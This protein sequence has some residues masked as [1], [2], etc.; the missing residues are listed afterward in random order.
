MKSGGNNNIWAIASSMAHVLL[1]SLVILIQFSGGIGN[2]FSLYNI[3]FIAFAISCFVMLISRPYKQYLATLGMLT[4]ALVLSSLISGLHLVNFSAK[5]LIDILTMAL[6]LALPIIL[7]KGFN[8]NRLNRLCK[9]FILLFALITIASI[10][11]YFFGSNPI[12]SDTRFVIDGRVSAGSATGLP[13]GGY[14][15]V[16]CFPFLYRYFIGRNLLFFAVIIPLV[17]LNI[18]LSGQRMALL[19]MVINLAIIFYYEPRV[20]K[21]VLLLCVMTVPFGMGSILEESRF[22]TVTSSEV[23]DEQSTKRLEGWLYAT[24]SISERP[25]WGLGLTD[26]ESYFGSVASVHEETN[27]F[28]HPHSLYL[29]VAMQFGLVGLVWFLVFWARN[30][31]LT[32]TTP[33]IVNKTFGL[34]LINSILSPLQ[35]SHSFSEVWFSILYISAASCAIY[36]ATSL[37]PKKSNKTLSAP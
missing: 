37:H 34:V 7:A 8:Q 24:Q 17:L 9:S 16:A 25:F 32:A 12:H 5:G 14:V 26:V 23:V 1:L 28:P 33:D 31:Y 4:M 2:T 6:C 19:L 3:I 21:V 13:F 10:Y 22:A 29:H 11:E 35:I 20:R 27:K 15:S 36:L 18:Y 30:L